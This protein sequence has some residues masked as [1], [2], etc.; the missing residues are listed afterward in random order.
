MSRIT[1]TVNESCQSSSAGDFI[2]R[3]RGELDIVSN[4]R[5]I[6][7]DCVSTYPSEV[8]AE[9]KDAALE[10]IRVGFA[11]VLHSRECGAH[12]RVFDLLIHPVDF[13]TWK[14][15]SFSAKYLAAA[16]EGHS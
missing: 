5:E 15:E 13:S 7:I 6:T 8:D 4:S 3:Y 10:A 16:L 9:Q 12:V 11:S 2:V 14:F 1:I